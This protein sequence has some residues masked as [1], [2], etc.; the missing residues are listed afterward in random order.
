M[1]REKSKIGLMVIFLLVLAGSWMPSLALAQ[2]DGDSN[3]RR[4][5]GGRQHQP[6]R[7]PLPGSDDESDE[8][9]GE[10]ESNVGEADLGNNPPPVLPKE[11]I[12][13]VIKTRASQFKYCYDRQLQRDKTIAGVIKVSFVIETSGE[14]ANAKISQNTVHPAVG[15]CVLS[16][17]KSLRF[18][19]R[20]NG[21]PM[22]I[23]YPFRF[24]A[25]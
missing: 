13:R 4:P 2:S 11:I 5:G 19:K 17:I 6:P 14:V 16:R 21:P 15:R 9:F 24:E 25:R 3:F 23:N 12:M 1:W 7:R 18:P 10:T 20:E 22:T 8:P